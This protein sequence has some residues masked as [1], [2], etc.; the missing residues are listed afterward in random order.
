MLFKDLTIQICLAY[1]WTPSLHLKWNAEK[2][3]WVIFSYEQVDPPNYLN[4]LAMTMFGGQGI[5]WATMP[6]SQQE[7]FFQKKI[8][9][10]TN[11]LGILYSLFLV[12][13][14]CWRQHTTKN[15]DKSNQDW[16][17]ASPLPSPQISHIY[18]E[19]C[20]GYQRR[21]VTTNLTL[22]GT[23]ASHNNEWPAGQGVPLLQ[24]WHE[25]LRSR[26]SMNPFKPF[27]C[28]RQ[29]SIDHYHLPTYRH[30]NKNITDILEMGRVC[31]SFT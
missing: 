12:R 30:S 4:F 22:V 17:D 1:T 2:E 16:C 20:T 7:Y 11:S 29:V 3:K 31:F 19:V 6:N 13:P 28:E 14:Y 9:I 27:G 24:Q 8:Y 10:Y 21:K 18:E 23:P 15:M 5:T 25:H 26:V